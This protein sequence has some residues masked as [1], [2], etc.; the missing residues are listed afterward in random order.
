MM[1]ACVVLTYPYDLPAF[2]PPL[3]ASLVKHKSVPAVQATVL[4]TVQLFK[5]THQD[6]W[7]DFKVLFSA[8]QLEDIQGA[9]AAHYYS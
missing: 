4:K 6:R 1:A 5:R 2:M 7:E 9:G 3:L 8:D